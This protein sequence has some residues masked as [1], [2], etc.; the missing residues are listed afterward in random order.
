MLASALL[1]T[2]YLLFFGNAIASVPTSTFLVDKYKYL[3]AVFRL[4]FDVLMKYKLFS[5][6]DK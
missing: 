5:C 2:R 4:W 1:S 3:H 6:Q